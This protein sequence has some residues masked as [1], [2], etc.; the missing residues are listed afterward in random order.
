MSRSYEALQKAEAERRRATQ[1][2]ADP[3]IT[4]PGRA[5]GKSIRNGRRSYAPDLN[6]AQL[7]PLVEE[8]YQKLRGN[9]FA[10]PGKDA[11][12]T[13]MVVAGAHGEGAT[14]TC[15]ILATLLA[16][17]GGGD[18]VVI[19]ANLRT[20]ALHDLFGIGDTPRGL[21][22]LI[23]NGFPPRDLV[24]PTSIPR[25]FV[26]PAGRALPT[27]SLVY[28][29][30][31]NRLIGELRNDFRYVMLDVSPV[32]DYSDASFLAPRVDGIVMVVRAEQ[33]RIENALKMKRQLEWAGGQ[34]IGTVLNGKKSYV[35]LM[36]QRLL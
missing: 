10:R 31:I 22:D 13:L 9:I 7:D 2:Q 12:K 3:V 36:L 28:Q 21:T 23:S 8:E 27:P 20:P 14:T 16:K 6:L 24:Q 25:L 29:E 15:S 34:V 30:P 18:V 26:V 32:I 17:T 11:L 4:P 1:G 19:D 33:T 5:K 35:P